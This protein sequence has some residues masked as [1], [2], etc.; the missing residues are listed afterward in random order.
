MKTIDDDRAP[1]G[2]AHVQLDEDAR[3]LA[4]EAHAL[5][6]WDGGGRFDDVVDLLRTVCKVPIALVSLVEQEQQRFLGRVGLNVAATPRSMSFCAHAMRLPGVMTVPDATADPRFADNPLVTGAPHIRF[7]AGCPLVT[8]DGVALGALCVIDTVPRG[9]L[10]AVQMQTLQVL[11]ASVMTIIEARRE[12][13]QRDL[14]ARELE[15]RI[16]NIFA[17]FGSLLHFADRADDPRAGLTELRGRVESLA[18]AHS[19]VRGGGSASPASASNAHALV[20]TLLDPHRGGCAERITIAGDDPLLDAATA[21]GVSL[22]IHE[23]AT[24]A[25]KYGAFSSPE[26][27]VRIHVQMAEEG[28]AID[29]RETGAAQVAMIPAGSGFGTRLV[30]TVVSHQLRGTIERNWHADGLQVRF[31]FPHGEPIASSG[32]SHGG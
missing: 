3:R 1:V 25:A 12:A 6:G 14:I 30:N 32:A 15:H 17:L 21:T 7:Y 23:L 20:D 4:L 10:D 18:R 13:E 9:G 26:G 5:V 2:E 16:Q 22:V 28:M 31:A 27:Q 24:N 11:A 19:L 29:W 8:R